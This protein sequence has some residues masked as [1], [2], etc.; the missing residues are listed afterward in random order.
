MPTCLIKGCK[1]RTGQKS[2]HP[3]VVL[4]TFPKSLDYIK[5]WLIQTKQDFGD[6]DAFAQ[7]VLDGKKTEG[8]RV[9]SKHFASSCYT[10]HGSK[11]LLK[12]DAIPTI[13][14]GDEEKIK[15]EKIATGPP[16]KKFK[17]DYSSIRI[18]RPP[19]ICVNASSQTT[20]NIGLKNVGI[21]TN[22]KYQKMHVTM[23]TYIPYVAH[24]GVQCGDGTEFGTK[25]K[26]EPKPV[27]TKMKK[28]SCSTSLST[29]S[30]WLHSKNS[31]RIK[32]EDPDQL[33]E[34]NRLLEGQTE[35][36]A[37]FQINESSGGKPKTVIIKEGENAPDPFTIVESDTDFDYESPDENM[38]AMPDEPPVYLERMSTD[39]VDER[40]F[41][42]F[43]SSLDKLFYRVQCGAGLDC[44]SPIAY[45]Q[46]KIVGSVMTVIGYCLSGHNFKIWDRQ[47]I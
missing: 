21:A 24:I 41:F 18:S 39:E 10:A 40:K 28:R 31:T 2:K 1:H 42:V 33:H 20:A 6:I 16:V 3:S 34:Y 11:F 13:F 30:R 14:P 37:D 7:K 32:E 15:R 8:H 17:A 46:K 27:S 29:N 12:E 45:V 38:D 25:I 44:T 43:E 36:T 19:A 26:S 4:H 35:N 23:Q 5:R 47:P 9:C 22:P